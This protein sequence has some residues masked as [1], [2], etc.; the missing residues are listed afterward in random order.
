MQ[1]GRGIVSSRGIGSAQ[2]GRR[3][4]QPRLRQRL[5]VEPEN[6]LNV[7]RDGREQAHWLGRQTADPAVG[8]AKTSS[9]PCVWN[10]ALIRAGVAENGTRSPFDE[11]ADARRP[12]PDSQ[13]RMAP[14][15]AFV[16][17]KRRGRGALDGV[18]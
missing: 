15:V 8:K 4:I 9:A 14:I 17:P 10:A 13:L 6:R 2:C 3:V 5:V 1:M 18:R 11:A 12:S 16:G 7:R